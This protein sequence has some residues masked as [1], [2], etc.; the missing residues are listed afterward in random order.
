M[1][2]MQDPEDWHPGTLPG[3]EA[4]HTCPQPH[5]AAHHCQSG[6]GWKSHVLG[7]RRDLEGLG[8]TVGVL[9]LLLHLAVLRVLTAEKA[10]T[11]EV[12][13]GARGHLLSKCL[14]WP[15]DPAPH[16]EWKT[17]GLRNRQSPVT[18]EQALSLEGL[19]GGT[20]FLSLATDSSW[21]TQR[22]LA[23]GSKKYPAAAS[24][25]T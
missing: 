1:V 24:G 3:A 20:W 5:Y 19:P 16:R 23:L 22:C 14:K 7:M 17:A 25:R 4:F 12:S 10:Q 21:V 2:G 8:L 6:L 18:M 11:A 13:S 9:G 15:H